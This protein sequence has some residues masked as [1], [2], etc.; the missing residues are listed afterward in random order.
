MS[1][2]L[3]GNEVFYFS[4]RFSLLYYFSLP[5][6]ACACRVSDVA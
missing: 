2:R 5:G 6:A 1:A 3:E 4:Q